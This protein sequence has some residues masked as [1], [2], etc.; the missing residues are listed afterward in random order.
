MTP[1]MQNFRMLK[2]NDRY[3]DNEILEE[4]K[5]TES[6]ITALL[7]DMRALERYDDRKSRMRLASCE[8]K[9]EERQKYRS[10]LVR[11]LTD[12]DKEKNIKP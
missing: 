11:I 7:S 6:E 9:V 3:S 12:R 2:D 10:S 1:S 4:I 8:S 5:Y